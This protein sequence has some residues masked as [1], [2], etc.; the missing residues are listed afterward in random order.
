VT[1][2]IGSTTAADRWVVP[3]T[4]ARDDRS[5]SISVTVPGLHAAHLSIDVVRSG[6]LE[7]PNA[8]QNVTVQPSARYVLP[9]S[10]FPVRDA[11]LVLESDEP[12]IVESTIYA[13]QEATR[14]PGIPSR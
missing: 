3:R 14:A 12:I 10:A 9:E 11:V 1:T 7:R 4:H 6:R 5:T 13:A 2:S 8:L